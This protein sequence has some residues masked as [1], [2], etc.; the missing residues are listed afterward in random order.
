MADTLISA[1]LMIN[2]DCRTINSTTPINIIHELQEIWCKLNGWHI[3]KCSHL[4]GS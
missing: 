3:G 1:V 2:G 4:S